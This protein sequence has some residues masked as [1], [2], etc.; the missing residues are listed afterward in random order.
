MGPKIPSYL[1][2]SAQLDHGV[3]TEN[4]RGSRSCAG[5]RQG[6]SMFCHWE[7]CPGKLIIRDRCLG[8]V[9]T[10][11][12]TCAHST[13]NDRRDVSSR[14]PKVKISYLS[15]HASGWA[16]QRPIGCAWER[17]SSRALIKRVEIRRHAS[18]L[19]LWVQLISDH[20]KQVLYI[21]TI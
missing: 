16:A 10:F 20:F 18:L 15:V 21:K 13:M 19:L 3:C 4:R 8:V 5:G 14:S 1:A 17:A 6:G 11:I 9:M 2:C 7:E 12:T